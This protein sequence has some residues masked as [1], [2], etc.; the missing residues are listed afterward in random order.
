MGYVLGAVFL[1]TAVAFSYG[2]FVASDLNDVAFLIAF[3]VASILFATNP[4]H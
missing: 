4:K 3:G 2:W 1:G